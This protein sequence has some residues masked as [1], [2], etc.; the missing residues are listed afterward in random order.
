MIELTYFERLRKIHELIN[1]Q[2]T[3]NTEAFVAQL[4]VFRSHPL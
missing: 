2:S 1:L 3:G 4:G